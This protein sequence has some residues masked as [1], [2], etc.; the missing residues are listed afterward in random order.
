MAKKPFGEPIINDRFG[1]PIIPMTQGQFELV[2]AIETHDIV[3]VNGPAGA[4]KTFIA[5]CMA[6]AAMDA[7][8]FKHLVLTRPIVESGEEL[9]FLPGT[10]EEKVEP[11]MRPLYESLEKLKPKRPKATDMNYHDSQIGNVKK[12]M[13][14][15]PL[16][17]PS[18]WDNAPEGGYRRKDPL[19]DWWSKVEVAPLAYM[20]GATFDN[21]FI[22]LDEAQNVQSSQM[23]LMLTRLGKGSKVV[24][25]GD[26]TQSDLDRRTKSGFRH[27]QHLLKGVDGIGFVTLTED[28]IV[29]HKLVRDI[30]IRYEHDPEKRYDDGYEIQKNE[31]QSNTD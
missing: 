29:R 1:N 5:T 25:C 21:S 15:K 20:R 14:K 17:K 11:Y 12:T 27:A 16:R 10:M 4:G 19:E 23:K 3:F 31:I 24:V 6:V 18:G 30:I 9:G 7:G 22:I 2:N 26:A 8:R 13:N 28:D